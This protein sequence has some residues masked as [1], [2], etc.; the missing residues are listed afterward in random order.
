MRHL[1]RLIL[2]ATVAVLAG[3]GQ[4]PANRPATQGSDGTSRADGSTSA[5]AS[6]N[7]DAESAPDAEPDDEPVPPPEVCPASME[8]PPAHG[9]D[10]VELTAM[11]ATEARSAA[12]TTTKGPL[13]AD[14]LRIGD[15]QF[16]DLVDQGCLQLGK[17]GAD[18]SFSMWLKASGGSQIIGTTDQY[19][20]GQG[21]IL[22]TQARSDGMLELIASSG[23]G[24]GMWQDVTSV[25][26]AANAWVHVGLRYRNRGGASELS[27]SVNMQARSGPAA[28]DVYNATLRIG[29][30]GWGTIA[31]FEVSETV[32]YGRYLA[33][34]ELKA[35]F[36]PG[37]KVAAMSVAT[38]SEALT[39]LE[40][41]LDA[42]APL[43]PEALATQSARFVA[44]AP[45]L[46]TDV[47]TMQRALDF[48][49]RYE[50][51]AG[52]LFTTNATRQGIAR[53][54]T[55]D[56][57]LAFERAMLAVQQALLD[58][59]F[60]PH[61]VQGCRSML[62]GRL[63][64]TSEYFPGAVE[65]AQD[66]DAARPVVISATVPAYWGRPVAFATEPAR[67]PTGLYLSPGSIGEVIVP[68]SMVD[69]GFSV[70]VGA[71]TAD[72]S[73]KPNLRRLDRVTRRFP[74]T[75]RV[76]HIGNP[77]G[78]GV[79]IE[80]P[81]LADLG[82][83]E[84]RV[85]GAVQAP[86]FS[87]KSF[88]TTTAAAWRERRTAPAPW[89]D[90]ETDKFMM[91]VPSSWIYAYDDP[92]PLL[93]KWDTAMDGVSELL[94]YP[95]EKRNRSVL[96][97]QVDVQIRHGAFGIGYPQVNNTYDPFAK[98]NGN[99]E[100]WLLTDPLKFEVEYHELGH[101]QL[102]SKFRGETEALVNFPHA[103]VTNV[104]FG[105]P[106]D[107]AFQ[108]S[109]G[110][111]YGGLGMSPDDA[112]IHW[113]ITENFRNGREMDHSNTTKDE[114][115]YQQ[116]GYAKYGDIFR[117]FGWQPL[118]DFY[119]NEHLDFMSRAPS[120]GLSEVDSR[121]LR[122]S[123]AA[124]ADLTPLI[125]F[126]GVHPVDRSALAKAMSDRKLKAS[127]DVRAHIERYKGIA[128]KNNA[129]FNAHYERVYPGRPAG[130][131]PDYGTGWY[132]AWRDVFNESHGAQIQ[133]QIQALLDLY[134]P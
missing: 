97:V 127:N 50:T 62:G 80:V 35:I 13:D 58:D 6:T 14:A 63:F 98:E 76:T 38:L 21:F 120:D 24:Q 40:K 8:P 126:W 71:H 124:G 116:R 59:V 86:F 52:P 85:R 72:H 36:L 111:S 121:I 75:D 48:V 16:L 20:R 12:I 106:F 34:R 29:D 42:S 77:L 23:D 44:S 15:E 66:P 128:P 123:I 117:I 105:V 134:Y 9:C 37:A 31:P 74:I 26:F 133:N 10:G 78:G 2:W 91:Q 125:H 45:L 60:T 7:N 3:C 112:A 118:R 129:D 55:P 27:L 89:A 33:D 11:S 65:P 51:Q 73:N 108:R 83:V 43:T 93:E 122:L 70:L 69:A 110:P 101:A 41:H 115:R 56:D 39:A 113:M 22:R 103:Y 30:R 92:R 47:P 1:D 32:A 102:F 104:K 81:Y 90:F 132:N 17:E 84:V 61:T 99:K 64:R 131:H 107:A 67:R 57:G 109:F 96:Y 53:K 4:G 25:P 119:R 94:G 87:L 28:P 68:Q 54:G 95:P 19:A 100:H 49:E 88:D 46:E 130:G 5:D 82:L 79:Y 18:F 114:F